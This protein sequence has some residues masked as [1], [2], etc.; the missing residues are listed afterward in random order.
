MN[1]FNFAIVINLKDIYFFYHNHVGTTFIF[2][3]KEL[4]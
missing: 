4:I 2:C 3:N 1:Y